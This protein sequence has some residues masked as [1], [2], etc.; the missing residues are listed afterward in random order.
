MGPVEGIGPGNNHVPPSL[1][2]SVEKHAWLEEVSEWAINVQ[3][4]AKAG[5][6]RA[7]GVAGTLAHTLYRS[8]TSDKKDLVKRAV[9]A[10]DLDLKPDTERSD[11]EQTDLVKKVVEIVA[12]DTPAESVRRIARLNRDANNCV[13][14]NEES[15]PKYIGR[16]VSHAQAYLNMVDAG[17]D[18]AESQNFAMTLL[19]N[20]KIPG[21]TFSALIVS[22]VSTARAN[23]RIIEPKTSIIVAK[24]E[25]I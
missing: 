22:I 21:Q 8:L 23:R 25:A 11:G 14:G 12:A 17:A 24:A 10:G 3:A 16:F 18:S 15:I 1:G 6:N 5:D 2:K 4:C 13:R 7:K 20:A 19:A 9:K